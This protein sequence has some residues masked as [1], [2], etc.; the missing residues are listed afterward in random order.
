MSRP[1]LFRAWAIASR[2][3]FY[4]DTGDGWDIANGAL[5]PLPNTILEQFT[6]LYDK[7]RTKEFPDGQPV[8]EGDVLRSFHFMK[9][10]QKQYLYH[11]VVWSDKFSCWY[12]CNID[13][14]KKVEAKRQGSPPLWV[15]MKNSVDVE[16]IGNIHTD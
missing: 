12:T 11:V 15:Y 2:Q 10:K 5:N 8:Y 13:E 1:I 4:P 16:V 14:Q 3:M 9:G 6:G 7:K